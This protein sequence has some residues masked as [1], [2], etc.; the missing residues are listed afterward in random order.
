MIGTI[1]GV[2]FR[3]ST[4][5]RSMENNFAKIHVFLS[6]VDSYLLQYISECMGKSMEISGTKQSRVPQFVRDASKQAKV[7]KHTKPQTQTSKS[8]NN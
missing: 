4:I 7:S 6:F 8:Q 3:V 1:N 5:F 2:K